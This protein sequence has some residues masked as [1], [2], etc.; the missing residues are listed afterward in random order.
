MV[1][2]EIKFS[3]EIVDTESDTYDLHIIMEFDKGEKWGNFKSTRGNRLSL[4]PN[5]LTNYGE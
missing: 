1:M 4:K 2:D 5:I 3:G